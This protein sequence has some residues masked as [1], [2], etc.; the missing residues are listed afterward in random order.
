MSHL[1]NR[2]AGLVLALLTA[3]FLCASDLPK[4]ELPA[5]T[6]VSVQLISTLSSSADR[7]GD[8]FTAQVQDPIFAQGV[9]VVPA[10]STLRG[11]VTFVKPPGRVKAKAEMRLVADAIVLNDGHE[12]TFS[13]QLTDGNDPSVRVNGNEGTIQGKGKSKTQ[14]AKESGIGA[15]AGAGVGALSAGGTGA[16]YGAGIGAV[17]GLIHTLAKHNK[18]VVLQ[19]GT[20][21]VFVLTSPGKIA[22]AS[23]SK[24]TPVP[25]VCQTCD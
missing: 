15:A 2:I 18:D 21:L 13:G 9:E 19:P 23:E 20:P 8:I 3:T 4:P 7:A 25:F 12:Y 22:N 16:L 17:A 1:K 10:G 6:Q 14:A 24:G 11:H 5:G